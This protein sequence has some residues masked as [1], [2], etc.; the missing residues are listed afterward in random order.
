MSQKEL[1][2]KYRHKL[3]GLIADAFV[4]QRQGSELS[5]AM[6]NSFRQVDAILAEIHADLTGEQQPAKP[7]TPR[8]P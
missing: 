6:R 4:V 1:V 3:G 7:A 2:E 8:K 5:I